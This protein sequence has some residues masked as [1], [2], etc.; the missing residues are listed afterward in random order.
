MKQGEVEDRS[1]GGL[2]V[3]LEILAT[4]WELRTGWRRYM[5]GSDHWRKVWEGANSLLVI[6]LERSWEQKY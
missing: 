2:M 4:S 6:G 3:W 5:D 1:G